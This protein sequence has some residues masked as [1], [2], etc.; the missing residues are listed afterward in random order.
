VFLRWLLFETRLGEFLLACL[1]KKTGLA[2][3][4]AKW[5]GAQPSGMLP[6]ARSE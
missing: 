6:V 4:E 5:L 1:E 3:V 2:V